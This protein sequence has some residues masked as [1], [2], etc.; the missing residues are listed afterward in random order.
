MMIVNRRRKRIIKANISMLPKLVDSN[1]KWVS[2]VAVVAGVGFCCHVF[3]E[4]TLPPRA[5][6]SMCS[7]NGTKMVYSCH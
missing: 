7:N 3:T 5:P 6:F 2:P 1:M 4:E